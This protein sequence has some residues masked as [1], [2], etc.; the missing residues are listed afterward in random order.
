MT[1]TGGAKGAAAVVRRVCHRRSKCSKAVLDA[2]AS[3]RATTSA[4]FKSGEDRTNVSSRSLLLLLLPPR[5]AVARTPRGPTPGHSW[6]S[7]DDC[8]GGEWPDTATSAEDDAPSPCTSWRC[9]NDDRC[10]RDSTKTSQA[11]A[12]KPCR[13]NWDNGSDDCCCGCCCCAAATQAST[14]RCDKCFRLAGSATVN[15]RS[16][17]IEHTACQSCRIWSALRTSQKAA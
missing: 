3:A 6:S 10:G 12:S 7:G 13:T 17:G 2:R 11:L 14:T 1:A 15:C 4:S 8:N 5:R 16:D 9:R